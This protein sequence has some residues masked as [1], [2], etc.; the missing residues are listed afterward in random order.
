MILLAVATFVFRK[1]VRISFKII[2]A[3]IS[4]MNSYVH[5]AITGI[6]TIKIFSREKQNETEFDELNTDYTDPVF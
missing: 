5:E 1:K 2:R 4:N 6:N 3:K